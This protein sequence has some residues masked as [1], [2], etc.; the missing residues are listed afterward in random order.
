VRWRDG[1]WRGGCVRWGNLPCDFDFDSDFDFDFDK[2]K[3]RDSLL[4]TS[5][6]A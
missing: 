6:W 3:R 4:W 2:D 5:D 1:L